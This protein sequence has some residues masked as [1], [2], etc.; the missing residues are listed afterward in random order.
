MLKTMVVIPTYNEI[1]NL[2]RITLALFNLNIDGLEVLVVDDASPDG[3]G[4]LA[5]QLVLQYPERFHVMHRPGK[6]GLGSAYIQ[7]FG[8]GV[9]QGAEYLVQMDADFSHSPAIIPQFLSLMPQYDVVIGSRYVK[10]G[11]LA[12]DW[13]WYRKLLSWWGNSIWVRLILGTKTRDA[14]AGFKCWRAKA[15][16]QLG[17]ERVR[18]NG[19]IF[20]VEMCYL[21]EKLGFRIKE[22]P[23][24][25]ADRQIG[26]SKMDNGI[27][28]EAA[29]RVFEI[30]H[31]YR[32]MQPTDGYVHQ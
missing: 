23:I 8:W 15:L 29:L 27:K 31:R 21:A 26:E 30:R 1:E 10:G 11:K 19:Y 18:S 16:T 9:Q 25:F 2:P 7:G 32:K 13:S 6:Q 22:I 4:E 17:L 12:E 5:D 20:Q 28:V 24:Y 3:T 14:T